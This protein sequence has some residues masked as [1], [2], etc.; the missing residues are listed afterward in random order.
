MVTVALFS[1]LF[2]WLFYGFYLAVMSL[3]RAK[4][5][6]RLTWVMWIL[7][8][9]YLLIGAIADVTTNLTFAAAVFWEWPRQWLVTQRL[10]AYKKLGTGWRYAIAFWICTQ[11][12]DAVDPNHSHCD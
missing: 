7:G 3:Y 10:K 8:I 9:P 5:E 4:L 11:M 2:L 12:L 1:L 6:K